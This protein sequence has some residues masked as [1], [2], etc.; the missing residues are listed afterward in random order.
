[1][2]R[3]G[4]MGCG[5][6]ASTMEDESDAYT[7]FRFRARLRHCPTPNSSQV[8]TGAQRNCTPLENDGDVDAL[9]HDYREMLAKETLDIVCVATHPPLHPEMVIASAEAGAKG[10]FCEKPMALSIGECDAMIDAC[11]QERE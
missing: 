8:V 5:R 3:V 9:Y 10:I 11:E 2:Y 7:P 6:I 1:M 4:I